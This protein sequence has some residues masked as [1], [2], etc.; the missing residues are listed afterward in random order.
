MLLDIFER[1]TSD[2][3]Y[4]T[5]GSFRDNVLAKLN[6]GAALSDDYMITDIRSNGEPSD[7]VEKSTKAVFAVT[8]QLVISVREYVF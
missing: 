8:Q 5:F 1:F 7:F 6:A 4:K 2:A 3:N